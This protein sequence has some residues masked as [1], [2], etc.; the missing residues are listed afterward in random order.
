MIH[1]NT[2]AE[3]G[4][5]TLSGFT[6]DIVDIT[7]FG[8]D[9]SRYAYTEADGGEITFAGHYDVTDEFGQLRLELA[10]ERSETFVKGD[11][12]FYLDDTSY[13]TVDTGG[14]L[15]ITKIKSIVLD[16]MSIGT[17]GFMAKVSGACLVLD[18]QPIN[19]LTTESIELILSE[20]GHSLL[21]E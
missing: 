15:I 9:I 6:R 1:G 20:F 16:Q 18:N 2:V 13:L 4:I 21:T 12:R 11:V 7:S 19:H 10:F 17:I 8:N 14:E 3:M 5:F